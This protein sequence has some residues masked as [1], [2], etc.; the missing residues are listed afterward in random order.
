MNQP[1]NKSKIVP[2]VLMILVFSMIWV[3]FRLPSAIPWSFLYI[4]LGKIFGYFPELFLVLI[5][6]GILFALTTFSARVLKLAKLSNA[7]FLTLI[8]KRRTIKLIVLSLVLSLLVILLFSSVFALRI[9]QVSQ[10]L[11]TFTAENVNESLQDYVINLQSFLNN[12]VNNSYNRPEASFEIDNWLYSTLLDP[13]ILKG[14]GVTRADV[15]IYQHWGAC[16]QAAI[17]IEE[18]MHDAG[19]ETRQAHFVDGDHSWAEVNYNGKWLIV[20]PWY[21]GNLVEI[22]NLKQLKSEFQNYTSVEVIYRNGTRFD[23]GKDYGY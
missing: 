7:E 2:L 10:K 13:I 3:G 17:V 6:A 8:R 4:E 5:L 18:L 21:I 9:E 11:D 22:N 1:Y 16:G 19:Y 23:L 14:L 12:N 15:I 20:D